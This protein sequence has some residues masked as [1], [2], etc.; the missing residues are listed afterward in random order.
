MAKCENGAC[1]IPFIEIPEEI[2]L[3]CCGDCGNEECP[4]CE[5]E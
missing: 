4:L 3:G 2:C 5:V 1:E